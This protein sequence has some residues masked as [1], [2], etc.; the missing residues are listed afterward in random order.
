MTL[1][2]LEEESFMNKGINCKVKFVKLR[3]SLYFKRLNL[4]WMFQHLTLLNVVVLF[5][6]VRLISKWSCSFG[7]VLLIPK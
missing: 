6:Q 4:L 1:K 3:H 5:K 2:H 7:K